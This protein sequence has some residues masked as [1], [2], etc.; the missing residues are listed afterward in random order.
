MQQLNSRKSFTLIE[1]L[2]VISIIALL[3][4][5]LLPA[6]QNARKVAQGAGCMSNARQLVMATTSYVFDHNAYYPR[7]MDTEPPPGEATR[8]TGSRS[9]PITTIRICEL[10]RGGTTL[11]TRAT[12]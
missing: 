1:L 11:S 2:V 7:A 4:A 5:L 12:S 8:T 9:C 10:T 3:I 6:L